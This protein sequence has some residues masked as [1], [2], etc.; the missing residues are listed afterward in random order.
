ME[1]CATR[2]KIGQRFLRPLCAQLNLTMRDGSR[3]RN[4]MDFGNYRK[5]T[6]EATLKFEP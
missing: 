5:F 4:I 3:A 1:S 6:S 2:L